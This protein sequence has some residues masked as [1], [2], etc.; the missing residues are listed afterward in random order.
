MKTRS[1]Y[2]KKHPG[3]NY[4]NYVRGFR[5]PDKAWGVIR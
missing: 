1:E 2:L 5:I 4:T 3:G